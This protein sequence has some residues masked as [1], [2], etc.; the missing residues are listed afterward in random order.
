MDP[1][2]NQFV[3][4]QYHNWLRNSRRLY[5]AD[6]LLRIDCADGLWGLTD[7]DLFAL[8][9]DKLL[10]SPDEDES[11]K[12]WMFNGQEAGD[13]TQGNSYFNMFFGNVRFVHITTSL[14]QPH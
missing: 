14:Y 13:L 12:N 10:K 4:E 7:L 6:R 2:P 9:F 5:Q 3:E 11:F 1:Y 8:H